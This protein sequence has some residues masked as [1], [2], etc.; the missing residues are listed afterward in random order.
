MHHRPSLRSLFGPLLPIGS[1]ITKPRCSA[2]PY[3]P[4]NPWFRLD[5]LPSQPSFRPPTLGH[6]TAESMPP[7]FPFGLPPATSTPNNPATFASSRTFGPAG[8][9]HARAAI[10]D[11]SRSSRL[12]DNLL[13]LVLSCLALPCLAL[14]CSP[15]NDSSLILI[16]S[17]LSQ[18]LRPSFAPPRRQRLSHP[19][20]SHLA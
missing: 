15:N 1:L 13:C 9:C 14:P 11:H 19:A 3:H 12:V 20:M 16:Q 8:R 5:T 4:S 2:L 7:S 18:V 10:P 6:C 17:R